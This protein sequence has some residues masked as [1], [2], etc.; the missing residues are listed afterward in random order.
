[1][2]YSIG[3]ESFEGEQWMEPKGEFWKTRFVKYTNTK[4]G[5]AFSGSDDD[6]Y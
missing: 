2:S 4:T 6:S 5:K 1:M 3:I